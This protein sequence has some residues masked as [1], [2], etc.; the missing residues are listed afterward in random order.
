M[1][2]GERKRTDGM[3][4]AQPWADVYFWGSTNVTAHLQPPLCGAMM[5]EINFA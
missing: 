1:E 2:K 5:I 4:Q 3:L